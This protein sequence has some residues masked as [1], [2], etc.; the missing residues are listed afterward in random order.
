MGKWF[1]RYR[2]R[3]TGLVFFAET[4]GVIALAPLTQVVIS[5]MGLALG[6]AGI[7]ER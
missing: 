4:A 5:P 7:G 1:Q 6:V 2:G 3:A